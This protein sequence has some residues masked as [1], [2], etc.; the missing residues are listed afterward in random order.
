MAEI[1]Q[2]KKSRPRLDMTPMVDLA[3]LLLTFFMLTTVFSKPYV[4]PIR[5]PEDDKKAKPPEVSATRVVTIILAGDDKIFW[6]K[7]QEGTLEET[8]YSVAGIRQVLIDHNKSIDDMMVFIK[9]SDE[10]RFK[11]VV[12]ILDEMSINSI[13]R[14]VVVDPT[15]SEIALVQTKL[16]QYE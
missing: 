4:L 1:D 3:F 9:P 16:K 11:N 15:P 6:Y 12:D 13:E 10:S 8:D 2:S 7:G 14:F 5:M